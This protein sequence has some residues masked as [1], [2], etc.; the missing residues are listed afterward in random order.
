MTESVENRIREARLIVAKPEQVFAELSKYGEESKESLFSGDEE[1]ERSL[2]ARA[3]PL[4][5]L[6]LARY[7]RE[8]EIVAALYRKSR[9]KANN[10]LTERYLK[11]LKLAC[12]SNQNAKRL[13]SRFATDVLGA[14]EFA[15]LIAEG[16]DDEMEAL[17]TNP[18]VGDDALE[19]LYKG[20]GLF[21]S[22]PEERRRRL[23]L[24][25]Q[26]NPRLTT[27]DDSEE[28]PDLGY[29]SIHSAILTML[30]TAPATWKWL[31][32][33]RQI[34]D[35][36]DSGNLRSPGEP[37]TNILERW[38]KVESPENDL[39]K[40][41][42]YTELSMRDEFLCLLA[43]MYGRN[44]YYAEDKKFTSAILGKPDSRDLVLRCSYYGKGDLTEKSMQEGMAKDGSAYLL[45]VL[46][47]ESV[48]YK[49][50]LRRLLEDEQL[51]GD[52]RYVYRRRCE[53]IHKRRPSFDPRP[54]AEWLKEEEAEDR[55]ES[56]E[57]ARLKQLDQRTAELAR[58][59]VGLQKTLGWV[60]WCLIILGGL[61]LYKLY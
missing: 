21:A 59:L 17:L 37:I 10:L 40:E 2:A 30:E 34:I 8:P 15:R 23:V 11:G 54:L 19:S 14:E 58:G 57:L 44:Y 33:L 4:I 49:P 29:M 5:D 47:N 55:T 50:A 56:E 18:I 38:S 31:V 12:L 48:Y 26:T 36:L 7:A 9:S 51:R 16:E 60:F 61:V 3:D 45:A 24:L 20:D 27:D 41:G 42:Y 39:H 25:S 46:C 35:R 13:L 43:A 1:L 28:G 53:Q 22:L 52:L 32:T 6:G